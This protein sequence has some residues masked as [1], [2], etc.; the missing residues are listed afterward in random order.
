MLN[1][2]YQIYTYFCLY[3]VKIKNCTVSTKKVTKKEEPLNV[4]LAELNKV[5]S[6]AFLVSL[7]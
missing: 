7:C 3:P 2:Y 6:L 1:I 4:N 5:K